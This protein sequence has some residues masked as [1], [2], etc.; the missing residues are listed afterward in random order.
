MP[1]T[2]AD[3]EN[4]YASHE[5][6]QD[7]NWLKNHQAPV[8]RLF[9]D[10]LDLKDNLVY[11]L[12]DPQKTI[13]KIK[14]SF[15][16]PNTRKFYL[17]ALLFLIDNYP[18]LSRQV[19][20]DQFFDAWQASKVAQV[21]KTEEK[22]QDTPDVGI[23]EIDEAIFKKFGKKS[24]EYLFIRWFREVP[25]RL[26][27]LDVKIDDKNA[28]KFVDLNEGQVTMRKYNKTDKHYGLKNIKLSDQLMEMIKS[29]LEEIPRTDLFV[30]SNANPTKAVKQIL[31][32]AGIDG[33]LNTIR[34][35]VA[36]TNMTPE[37]RVELSKKMGHAPTTSVAYKRPRKEF[38]RMDIP[39]ALVDDVTKLISLL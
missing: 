7:K 19:K 2:Q 32:K 5:K 36:S 37:E 12:R 6:S 3:I 29:S 8:V 20:R 25:T 34:H 31:K 38:K 10:C 21:E 18:D 16:N 17:Q 30:F 39:D 22:R 28:D 4:F 27:F 24:M 11:C 35:A 23:D 14:E 33:S 26:D 15:P 1:I 9:N 13:N